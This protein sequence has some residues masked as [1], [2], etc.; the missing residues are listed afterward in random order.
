MLLGAAVLETF[1]T[2]WVVFRVLGVG[3]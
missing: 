2:P 3:G 1:L